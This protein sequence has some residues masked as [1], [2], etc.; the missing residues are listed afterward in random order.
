[1]SR[2]PGQGA[3]RYLKTR[4]RQVPR[5]RHPPVQP[6]CGD[7]TGRHV[8]AA[9][10]CVRNFIRICPPLIITEA[11]LDDVIGRLQSAIERSVEGHPKDIDFTASSS[12]AAA[13]GPPR[14]F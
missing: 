10:I 5:A 2:R 14:V 9:F 6:C 13:G 7:D 11:Q 1:M 3:I 12:L 8:G 4:V